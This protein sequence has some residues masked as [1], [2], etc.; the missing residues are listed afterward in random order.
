MD[1]QTELLREMIQ[2]LRMAMD[3]GFTGV[4]NRLDVLNGRTRKNESSI[5][6]LEERTADM[7]CVKHGEKFHQLERDAAQL[8]VDIERLEEDVRDFMVTPKVEV[9]QRSFGRWVLT[10][11]AVAGALALLEGIW[12]YLKGTP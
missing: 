4:H 12:K 6:V 7:V 1:P 8:K 11:G 9:E 3:T 2:D 10:G 5:A